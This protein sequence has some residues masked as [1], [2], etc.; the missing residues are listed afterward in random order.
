MGAA[1]GASGQGE[2]IRANGD[3][4]GLGV[5]GRTA[6][7]KAWERWA[8]VGSGCVWW[9]RRGMIVGELRGAVCCDGSV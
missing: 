6:R 5:V 8:V 2:V 4:R 9:R 1:C 7:A 3:V